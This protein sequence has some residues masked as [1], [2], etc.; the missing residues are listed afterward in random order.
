MSWIQTKFKTTIP[1]RLLC[2]LPLFLLYLFYFNNPKI[3]EYKDLKSTGQN[4]AINRIEKVLQRVESNIHVC[5]V[6]VS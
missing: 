4:S 3:F 1:T 6:Y 2:T 5:T